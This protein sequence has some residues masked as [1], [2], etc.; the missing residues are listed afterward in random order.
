MQ[1]IKEMKI[2]HPFSSWWFRARFVIS[3][4]RSGSLIGEGM[5]GVPIFTVEEDWYMFY[6]ATT[7][8]PFVDVYDVVTKYI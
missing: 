1:V 3:R 8:T 6:G 7:M 4:I 2:Y 5:G